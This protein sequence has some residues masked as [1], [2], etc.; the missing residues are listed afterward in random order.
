MV[1]PGIGG[2]A[3]EMRLFVLALA[4]GVGLGAAVPQACA[5]PRPT[6]Q[7]IWETVAHDSDCV[8]SQYPDFV[9]VTCQKGQALWYFTKPNHPANPGVI[10][11]SIIQDSTGAISI[12]EQGWSFA[13]DAAQP[14]FKAWLGQIQDLDRKAKE[15]LDQQ[16]G[17]SRNQKSN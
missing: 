9:L 16:R 13:S 14:A 11:R 1:G 7:S 3:L 10:K 17:P 2:A 6:Y 15:Y 4:T 8:P 12:K 5:Q